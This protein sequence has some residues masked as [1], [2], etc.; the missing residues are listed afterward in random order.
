MASST[1]RMRA[2]RARKAAALEAVPDP[3]DGE[4]DELALVPAVEATLAALKLGDRDAAAGRLALRYAAA[5]DQAQNPAGALR[6]LG[7]LLGKALAELHATP[8]SRKG[9]RERTGRSGPNKVA[10]LR[11]A[12]AAATAKRNRGA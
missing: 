5:I 9:V 11:A 12:H 1:E 2:L 4:E 10:Q 3:D 6:A 8:A 7:P